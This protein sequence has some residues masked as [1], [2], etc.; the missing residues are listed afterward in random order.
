LFPVFIKLGH[1]HLEPHLLLSLQL[2]PVLINIVMLCLFGYSLF[3]PPPII[4]RLAR[5]REP[6]L[7][8]HAILYTRRITQVWCGFFAINGSISFA[9]AMWAS[10][11]IWSLYNGLIAYLLMGLLFGSEYL[12]RQRFKRRHHV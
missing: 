12:I 10:P 8:P 9:T 6:D 7:P 5:L 11:A 4:E 2:Y 1:G 3:S